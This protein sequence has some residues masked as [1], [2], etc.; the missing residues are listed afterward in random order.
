[1]QTNC[2]SQIDL[3]DGSKIIYW[4]KL[5]QRFFISACKFSNFT[6]RQ[7]INFADENR[8]EKVVNYQQFLCASDERS[9][10]ININNIF[11]FNFYANWCIN[12]N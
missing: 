5:R 11:D 9:L 1:M 3:M 4:A 12:I 2:V 10:W 8:A 7:L 6:S